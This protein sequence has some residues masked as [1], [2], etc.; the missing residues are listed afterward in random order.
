MDEQKPE[1][2]QPQVVGAPVSEDRA[3]GMAIAAMI[4]GI[5]GIVCAWI[6]GL[7]FALGLAA[8]ILGII[9][10]K[11]IQDKQSSAKGKGM[12]LT[13]IILGSLTLFGALMYVIIAVVSAVSFTTWL[14][15][16]MNEFSSFY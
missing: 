12:A 8:L 10:Y 11:R 14:P 2:V 6:I 1:E 5:V 9:E 4:V 13:G 16:I 3:S 15:S 7:N